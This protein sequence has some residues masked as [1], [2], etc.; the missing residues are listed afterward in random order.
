VKKQSIVGGWVLAGILCGFM[1]V[2]CAGCCDGLQKVMS[3]YHFT[4]ISP[5]QSNW[6]N[7]SV[8]EIDP[9]YPNAPTLHSM[10]S[11]VPVSILNID[12]QA[13]DVS[14]NYSE[15]LD[16]SLGL[17]LPDEIKAQLTAQGVSQYSVVATG[18]IL[19]SVPLDSYVSETFPKIAEKFGGD[20]TIPL[21]EGRLYYFYEVWLCDKL[22]YKFYDSKG[23]NATITVPIKIPVDLTAGW[24]ANEDGSLVFAGPESICL[25]YMARPVQVATTGKTEPEATKGGKATAAGRQAGVKFDKPQEGTPPK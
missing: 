20:W 25:G 13:P 8:V 18:N 6:E 17:S 24:T 14:Q 5:P 15:K 21:A 9:R 2:A 12:H 7:G 11:M 3:E 1:L 10:P 4:A 22:T 23:A 16:L 19:R